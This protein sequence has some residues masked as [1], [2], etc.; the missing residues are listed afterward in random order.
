MLHFQRENS[1]L[2]V[3]LR[4]EVLRTSELIVNTKMLLLRLML[5][6]LSVL[7]SVFSCADANYWVTTHSPLTAFK[8]LGFD[9]GNSH[10][11]SYI[12]YSISDY[13]AAESESTVSQRTNKQTSSSGLT[14]IRHPNDI[15]SN[16]G[17][18]IPSQEILG[19]T[20]Y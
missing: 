5:S 4:N 16:M 2:I 15:L 19:K 3:L 17:V 13:H 18:D 12:P 8:Q 9:E 1:Q 6:M 10:A 14:Q 7:L 11:S 20:F